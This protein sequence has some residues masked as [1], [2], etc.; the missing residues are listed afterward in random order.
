[1][2]TLIIIPARF[3]SSRFPGKPL[4]SLLGK[5]M[6]QW[7]LELSSKVVGI[8]NVYVATDNKKISKTV[9]NLGYK[10]I[11]TSK[12]CLTGT[13]RLA[14]VAK[15]LK[16]DI[17]INVQGDEPLVKPK[18]I[19]KIISEK[20]KY[21]DEV[22]NGYTTVEKHEN[23]NNINIPKVIFTNDKQLLYISRK[24]LPGFKDIKNKPKLYFKQ[25]CIYAFNRQELLMYG[26]VKKKGL[27]ERAEDIEII[28]FMELNKKIRM[29]KTSLGSLAVDEPRD[30]KKVEAAL[31]KTLV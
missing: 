9:S 10:S 21:F 31:Q 16:A 8:N 22:I 18:D 29:I 4:A 15:K 5:P 11:M 7:V 13:D 19:K 27:L 12:K 2:K 23:V 1:M 14:E 3:N 28:R 24:S 25:V 6:I 26:K 20:K 30:I 17:Y